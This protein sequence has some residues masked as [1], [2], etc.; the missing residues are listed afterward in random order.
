[1]MPKAGQIKKGV[2]III[3]RLIDRKGE[4]KVK[5]T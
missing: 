5:N 3:T 2:L 1:M 4:I